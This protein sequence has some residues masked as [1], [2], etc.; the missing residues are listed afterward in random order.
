M[1]DMAKLKSIR[2]LAQTVA[3]ISLLL[4]IGLISYSAYQLYQINQRVAEAEQREKAL[5]DVIKEK[6]KSAEAKQKEIDDLDSKIRAMNDILSNVRDKAP[7]L[8]QDAVKQTIESDPRRASIL[9]R[10]YLH[11]IDESQRKRA[12]DIGSVL[13]KNGYIVPSIEY[14]GQRIPN[15]PRTQLRYFNKDEQELKDVNDI[16]QILKNESVKIIDRPIEPSNNIR[17]RHYEI[18]FGADF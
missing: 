1:I 11:I 2:K 17:P 16:L 15:F 4:F 9:P 7:T 12:K 13:Q 18:W 8:A 14:V 3:V 5:D 10:I 6:E